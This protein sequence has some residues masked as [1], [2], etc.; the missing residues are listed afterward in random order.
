MEEANQKGSQ[1]VHYVCT[2]Y[3]N[4]KLKKWK[5][6]GRNLKMSGKKTFLWARI[7]MKIISKK[8]V[9]SKLMLKYRISDRQHAIYIPTYF[10]KCCNLCLD[11]KFYVEP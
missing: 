9:K 10:Q 5:Y 4:Q 7:I 8:L 2:C 11:L 1:F 6:I 3:K